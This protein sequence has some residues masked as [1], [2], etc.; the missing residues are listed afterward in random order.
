MKSKAWRTDGSL[1]SETGAYLDLAGVAHSS[2]K[3]RPKFS[4]QQ[5]Q[6]AR[7]K[8]ELGSATDVWPAPSGP[9]RPV[10]CSDGRNGQGYY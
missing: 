6:V 9:V 3:L 4:G 2:L 1:R 5:D 7:Q 8:C 10:F